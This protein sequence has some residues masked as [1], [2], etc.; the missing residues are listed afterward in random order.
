ML[1]FIKYF[2]LIFCTILIVCK[3]LNLPFKS[4][5][6]FYTFSFS[7]FSAAITFT[8]NT[9][10][11]YLPMLAIIMM[12]YVFCTHFFQNYS[13]ELILNITLI[14]F[15]LSCI[16]YHLSTF[17]IALLTV[18]LIP[19]MTYE[20]NHIPSH[21]A[22][23]IAH[24]SF[25]ILI[26]IPKRT[27]K[28]LALLISNFNN[29]T[30]T[31]IS[32]LL[33]FICLILTNHSS[34]NPIFVTLYFIA[35]ICIIFFFIYW[36]NTIT[37]TYHDKRRDRDLDILNEHLDDL[38][39]DYQKMTED[40]DELARIV[41]RDNK[42]VPAMLLSVETF[43][44]EFPDATPQMKKRGDELMAE[45][46]EAAE[47]RKGI[48]LQQ[49]KKCTAKPIE[50][51]ISA[52]DEVLKYMQEKAMSKDIT[53]SASA[54]LGIED[55][56]ST[57]IDETDL[58]T[59]T[60]DL[61]ENAIIA[62]SYNN[63]TNVYFIIGYFDK[64]L[65]IHVYDSGI[66]FTKEVLVDLGVTKHTTHEEDGGSGI[67]SMEIFKIARKYRAS[68]I[69]DEYDTYAGPYTKRISIIFDKRNKYT[70]N[71][72]RPQDEINYLRQRTDLNIEARKNRL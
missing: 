49:D 23:A 46:R 64:R 58:K 11:S 39:T 27:R 57:T 44:T 2:T 59:L 35:F 61:L 38:E 16:T 20:L 50:T 26:L 8:I 17:I 18:M 34:Y 53:L 6:I 12:A 45:L 7:I 14:A 60:N 28:G 67:G 22:A 21:I 71:T 29:S 51:G 48:I 65:A 32:L 72:S 30:F 55:L 10:F 43:L 63:G 40:K 66:P 4:T 56:A 15:G 37:R 13:A 52:L 19:Q 41:H 25:S 68:Y 42:L 1:F 62:N 47:G 69:I 54:D 3:L 5:T 9:F 70:L 31:Y 36:R 24:I 33:L